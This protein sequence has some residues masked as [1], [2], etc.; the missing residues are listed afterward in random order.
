LFEER[1][2]ILAQVQQF[3]RRYI[4]LDD[5]YLL[6]ASA[7]VMASW[8]SEIWSRFP[9]L[10]ITS[11]EMRCAK[12]RLLEVLKVITRNS[13]YTT[14]LTPAVLYRLIEREEG[15]LTFLVDECQSLSR[16]GSET[17][18]VVREL[19]NSAIER[20]AIVWRCG[21]AKNDKLIPFRMYCPKAFAMIGAPDPVLADRCLQV[22]LRRKTKEEHV[23][24][25]Y[26][27]AIK[28]DGAPIQQSLLDW[29]TKVIAEWGLERQG[30]VAEVYQKIK[31]FDIENDRMAELLLPLQTVLT[32]E[33]E[34]EALLGLQAYARSLD[35]RDQLE[36]SRTVG[37]ILLAALREL[38]YPKVTGVRKDFL[39]TQEIVRRLIK[40]EH[41]PW[42]E[43]GK[44]G[45]P[46]TPRALALLLRGYGVKPKK[47]KDNTCQGYYRHDLEDSWKRYLGSG[48]ESRSSHGA[49]SSST[50]PKESSHPSK[51]SHPSPDS[52]E[53]SEGREGSEDS[54]ESVRQTKSMAQTKAAIKPKAP[55]K[56]V[57][58][59]GLQPKPQ[60]KA[61]H[62][63]RR[64][65]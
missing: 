57:T 31:P 1:A 20:E 35:E 21:G 49:S 62:T 38:F 30:N 23:E 39:S 24:R 59:A 14:N 25:A 18:E 61:P 7:W 48:P 64:A 26:L 45:T 4:V 42:A 41:E 46:L 60:P 51:A 34:T 50:P 5:Q 53:G 47:D 33:D 22:A 44:G 28:A 13:F 58:K 6:A 19:L 65:K 17:S 16:L 56:P 3:L 37:V 8:L 15:L 55:S 27:D 54:L 52:D 43:I 9:H 10:A 12:T 36:E 40:R 11:P 32:L 29:S 63:T 2:G